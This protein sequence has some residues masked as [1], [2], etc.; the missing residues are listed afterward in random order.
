M[1]QVSQ[2][3]IMAAYPRDTKGLSPH[4]PQEMEGLVI[5]KV[6]EEDED[7]EDHFQRENNS[8]ELSPQFL[9]RSTT[10]NER[11]L[12]SSYL[13]AYHVAKEKMAHTAAEKI[14]LPT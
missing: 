1:D 14:I 12:L 8:V 7:E 5:V 3:L 4:T 2:F 9:S 6:E 13:V 11:A 10:I